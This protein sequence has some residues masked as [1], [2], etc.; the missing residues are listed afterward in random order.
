MG[1]D[2][3]PN[4]AITVTFPGGGYA[5][6]ILNERML[7]SNGTS[8]TEGTINAI[9]AFVFSPGGLLQAEVIVASAHSDAHV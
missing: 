3:S 7:N 1:A 4:T 8:D 9:H 5:V 6:V 2:V